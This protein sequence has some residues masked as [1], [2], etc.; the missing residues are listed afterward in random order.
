M[1]VRGRIGR[2][3]EIRSSM[4]G[5][6]GFTGRIIGGIWIWLM[7]MRREMI[8][9]G[10]GATTIE[11]GSGIIDE[12]VSRGGSGMDHEFMNLVL[13]EVRSQRAD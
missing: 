12:V 6:R 4:I 11:T 8:M 1:A 10:E 3:G 9:G 13:G 5:R 2:T 7:V